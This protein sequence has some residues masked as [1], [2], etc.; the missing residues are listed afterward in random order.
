[1]YRRAR[2]HHEHR[3]PRR[4]ADHFGDTLHFIGTVT[5]DY[6]SNWDD[7]T[8]L[9]SRTPTHIELNKNL[10]NGQAE[11]TEAQHDIATLYSADGQ[12][13][14]H[15]QTVGGFHIT[16]AAGGTF[17]TFDNWFHQVCGA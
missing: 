13:L 17:A 14:G 10:V 11:M 5:Q 12:V 1:M 15:V 7:G 16:F 4:P 6:R 3:N 2:N 8:Y 9:I